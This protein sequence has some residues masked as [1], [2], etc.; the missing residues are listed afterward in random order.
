M[1]YANGS[2]NGINNLNPANHNNGIL[3]KNSKGDYEFDWNNC[4]RENKF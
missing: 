4:I 3:D 1:I 2:K